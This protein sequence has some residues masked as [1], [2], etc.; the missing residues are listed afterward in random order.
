[1]ELK[2]TKTTAPKA[3]PIDESNLPFGKTF[4]DHM[5][6]IDYTEGTQSRSTFTSSITA[7]VNSSSSI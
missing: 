1:M 3:K 5:L 6:I 2:I 4:T 7:F